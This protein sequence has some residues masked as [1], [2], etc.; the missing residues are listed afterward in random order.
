MTYGSFP[1][2]CDANVLKLVEDANEYEVIKLYVKHIDVFVFYEGNEKGR[3]KDFR[4]FENVE[5]VELDKQDAK[6]EVQGDNANANELVVK[7]DNNMTYKDKTTTNRN[8]PKGRNKKNLKKKGIATA[9]P[10]MSKKR[11]K[12]P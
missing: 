6:K 10:R 3:G 5:V 7:C 2:R 9:N 12:K 1:L 8:I 11:K 4:S